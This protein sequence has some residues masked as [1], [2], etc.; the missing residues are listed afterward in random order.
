[1]VQTDLRKFLCNSDNVIQSAD[2]H[3][4]ADARNADTSLRCIRQTVAKAFALQTIN[5]ICEFWYN[6]QQTLW[7]PPGDIDCASVRRAWRFNLRMHRQ[8]QIMNEVCNL[9]NQ[10]AMD[11]IC[12]DAM[13]LRISLVVD[14]PSGIQ[15]CLCVKGQ[16]VSFS[17]VQSIIGSRPRTP[18]LAVINEAIQTLSAHGLRDPSSLGLCAKDELHMEMLVLYK[19]PPT[20]VMNQAFERYLFTSVM[21]HQFCTRFPKLQ[22]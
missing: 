20:L 9:F 16:V 11:K 19:Y 4:I 13:A 7:L 2:R 14:G 17:M 3:F 18:S 5:S 10:S 8:M 1:M 22:V 21:D 6:D 12:T 15:I